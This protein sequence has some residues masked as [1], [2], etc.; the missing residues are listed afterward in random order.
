KSL[1]EALVALDGAQAEVEAAMRAA[2]FDPQALEAAEERLFALRALARKHNV[3]VDDLA[4]LR[5][6][7]DAD[8]ADLDAGA[9]RLAGMEAEAVATKARYDIAA[10]RLS[11]R[12]R[13]TAGALEAAVAAELPALKLERAQFIVELSSEP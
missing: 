9:G 12:R 7:M 11:E 5:D 4:E 1:D 8:L 6:R 10:R 13:E 3:Q 2:E